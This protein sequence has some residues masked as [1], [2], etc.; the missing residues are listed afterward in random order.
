M[1]SAFH[2]SQLPKHAA[3]YEFRTANG[4]DP[5][6]IAD[7]PNARDRFI[8]ASSASAGLLLLL[9][10]WP[11]VREELPTASLHVYYGFW[12]YAMWA[13]QKPLIDLRAQIDPLLKAPGVVY[14]GMVSETELAQAYAQAGWYAYPSDKP[15]TSGIA[16]MKAQACG[17]VPITSG[18]LASALP[19]TVGSWDLGPKARHG[20]I[21]IEPE[22]QRDY[23]QALL[24]AVRRPAAEMV[25]YRRE[26][27]EAARQRFSWA[28]VAAQWDERFRAA[29][30]EAGGSSGGGGSG[31]GGSGGGSGS[32][33][34]VRD[35]RTTLQHD[36]DAL[37]RKMAQR[38]EQR[39]A[40]GGREA[41]V[42]VESGAA[43]DRALS[44]GGPPDSESGGDSSPVRPPS[45]PPIPV[46]FV[47]SLRMPMAKTL[48]FARRKPSKEEEAELFA[49][50]PD[51]ILSPGSAQ[52]L[53]SALQAEADEGVSS[54]LVCPITCELMTDPVFTMDGQVTQTQTLALTLTLTLTPTLTLALTL[55]LTLTRRTSAR[56]SRRG[57]ATT[58]PRPPPASRCPTRSSSR[59]YARE[60][61]C[62]SYPSGRSGR[63]RASV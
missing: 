56:P 53:R 45:P 43:P 63:R 50:T 41:E 31:G 29:K 38:S 46:E 10:M 16:L 1:L 8:Y 34:P 36:A 4:L 44:P 7:G 48:S 40:K 18:Q 61:C 27:K 14:H 39:K 60:A 25:R 37:T 32:G 54:S 19:E 21:G 5:Q 42:S 13:E 24:E 20:K 6:A 52:L 2:G 30:G 3:P 28:S 11:R 59:T 9:Q 47:Q 51:K 58:T 35:R 12:P 26:M 49:A 17:A 15:E 55:T 57:C 22:W 23:V 33:A 62:A